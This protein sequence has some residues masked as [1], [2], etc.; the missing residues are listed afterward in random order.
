MVVIL[1]VLLKQLE[2]FSV[3]F[4]WIDEYHRQGHLKTPI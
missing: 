2:N 3:Q 4:L 1:F